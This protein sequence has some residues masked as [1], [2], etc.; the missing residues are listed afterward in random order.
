VGREPI[1][2]RNGRELIYR[3]E[4]DMMSVAVEG[5]GGSFTFK[6]AVRLFG[7]RG[8]LRTQ[9]PWQPVAGSW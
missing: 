8:P 4:D 5:T 7:M 6:P 2:N 3:Q 9:P 1:W